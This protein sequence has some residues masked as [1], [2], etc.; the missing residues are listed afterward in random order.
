[1]SQKNWTRLLCLI[2][3]PEIE[4]YQQYLTQVIVHPRL[5]LCLKNY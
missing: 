1:M 3:L 4:Q 5:I 2:T